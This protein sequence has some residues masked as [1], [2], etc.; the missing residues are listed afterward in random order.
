MNMIRS[1]W[2][3]ESGQGMGDY[4]LFIMALAIVL[5][6]AIVVFKDEILDF[7]RWIDRTL[8]TRL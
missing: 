4:S 2:G 8:R 7:F 1:F 6:A 5:I 3:D